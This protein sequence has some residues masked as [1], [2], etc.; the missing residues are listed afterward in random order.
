MKDS[1]AGGY[2]ILTLQRAFEKSSN[3]AISK[4]ITKAYA[5]NPSQFTDHLIQL[6]LNKKLGLQINGEA[7]PLVKT[8]ADKKIWYSTSLPWLSI[9]YEINVSPMQMITLYNAIANNGKMVKPLLVKELKSIGKKS[10]IINTVVLN[11]KICSDATLQ[12]LMPLLT[13]VVEH[14]TAHTLKNPNYTIAGKTGTAQVADRN[15]GYA[16]KVYQS[17]FVGFFP[18]EK[19]KYTCMVVINNPTGGVYYGA[20][21]AGPVF[22]EIADK[23]YSMNS[24]MQKQVNDTA[25][26]KIN[27]PPIKAG[28]INDFKNIS[29]S[30]GFNYFYQDAD[31]GSD[32]IRPAK[33]DSIYNLQEIRLYDSKVPNVI[34]MSARDALYI[35]ENFG[36][37]VKLTGS[38]K[39][40]QQSITAGTPII[41]TIAIELTLE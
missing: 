8:P 13:G 20:L 25:Y 39:V 28:A 12:K 18:A 6:G 32:F 40:V 21:V 11:E 3:V 35:L 16:K 33:T 5:K 9:G 1:E 41:R 7:T 24:E 22:K 31:E 17:S 2:G 19:P 23:I 14:G 27:I 4:F 29:A 38:G 26:T 15:L 34:G 37:S 10:E 30:F 36:L